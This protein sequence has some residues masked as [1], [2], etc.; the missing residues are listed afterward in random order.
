[1]LCKVWESQ[2][3]L[4]GQEGRYQGSLWGSGWQG[5]EMQDIVPSVVQR[6]N[7]LK[8]MIDLLMISLILNAITKP[9]TKT[10]TTTTITNIQITA[11]H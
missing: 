2:W 9:Q 11:Q 1:M 5:Q 7:I 6:R 4:L 10:T 3:D 8:L